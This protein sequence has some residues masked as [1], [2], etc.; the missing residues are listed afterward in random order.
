MKKRQTHGDRTLFMSALP[1][2]IRK[3][4]LLHKICDFLALNTVASFAMKN[5][6]KIALSEQQKAKSDNDDERAMAVAVTRTTTAAVA[7]TIR[8]L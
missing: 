7:T 5:E 1:H 4:P 3:L 6:M 8:R 2:T